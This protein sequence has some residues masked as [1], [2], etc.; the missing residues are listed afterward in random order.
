MNLVRFIIVYSD[1]RARG[2]RRSCEIFI[3]FMVK[4]VSEVSC[5]DPA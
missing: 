2:Y 4:L 3:D 5:W 1:G